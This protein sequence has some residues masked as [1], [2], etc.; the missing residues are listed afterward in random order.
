MN[1]IIRTL[2]RWR[3]EHSLEI[4]SEPRP[5]V[6]PLTEEGEKYLSY[7]LFCPC[8]QVPR[9]VGV[10]STGSGFADVEGKWTRCY[11]FI[12]IED[13]EKLLA[14]FEQCFKIWVDAGRPASG[15]ISP[16]EDPYEKGS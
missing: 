7:L 15:Q 4:Q 2:D 16:L 1:F 10:F 6:V 3:R 8:N 11:R 14:G 9:P 12:S 13:P 5:H